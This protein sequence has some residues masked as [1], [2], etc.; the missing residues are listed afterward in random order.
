[1]HIFT[2]VQWLRE[3][4]FLADLKSPKIQKEIFQAEGKW[5]QNVAQIQKNKWRALEIVNVLL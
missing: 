3:N 5:H 4:S 1:M 2:D